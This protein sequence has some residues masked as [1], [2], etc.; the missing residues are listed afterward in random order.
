MIALSAS[1]I[2]RLV[3]RWLLMPALGPSTL[4]QETDSDSWLTGPCE[5][6]LRG[7]N[8][9]FSLGP[10][11]LFADRETAELLL[12][13][14]G[15]PPSGLEVGIVTGHTEDGPWVLTFEFDAVGL[16]FDTQ[17]TV[18]DSDAF[19]QGIREATGGSNRYRRRISRSPLT[20]TRWA[21]IPRHDPE[22]HRMSWAYV[23]EDADGAS[24]V[25]YSVRTLLRRGVLATTLATTARGFRAAQA[26]ADAITAG[27]RVGAAE[28]WDAHTGAD[29]RCP[30][31]LEQ[32]LKI[33]GDILGARA[34]LPS[35]IRGS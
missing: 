1:R 29:V 35:D 12:E 6:A 2:S 19:L 28:E 31:S 26:E 10:E 20:V 25:N 14:A 27:M 18:I 21:A 8:T 9:V 4:L 33:S 23:V 16:V 32:L 24:Y 30:Y 34:P 17:Q 3:S 13:S 22:K 5:V 15:N 7:T 11:Q